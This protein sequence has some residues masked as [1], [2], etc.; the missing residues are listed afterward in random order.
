MSAEDK[1]KAL[2]N[3]NKES[4]IIMHRKDDGKTVQFKVIDSISKLS[5]DDWYALSSFLF[6]FVLDA[7][8]QVSL[9]IWILFFMCCTI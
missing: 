6:V 2:P 3:A 5:R 7:F 1:R 8:D 9:E 4:E